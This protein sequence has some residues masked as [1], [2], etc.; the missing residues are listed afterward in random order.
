MGPVGWNYVHN[1]KLLHPRPPVAADSGNKCGEIF[2][3]FPVFPARE[4]NIKSQR[5][6]T[7]HVQIG[8]TRRFTHARRATRFEFIEGWRRIFTALAVYIGSR[9]SILESF[10]AIRTTPLDLQTDPSGGALGFAG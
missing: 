7:P 8:D 6:R 1:S 2:E 10:G 4:G 9:R 5:D 3:F